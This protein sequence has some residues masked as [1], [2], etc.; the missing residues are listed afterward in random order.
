MDERDNLA[1]GNPVEMDEQDN[2]VEGNPVEMDERDNFVDLV[3]S[4]TYFIYKQI[5]IKLH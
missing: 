1:E 3:F 2:L 5:W 4:D